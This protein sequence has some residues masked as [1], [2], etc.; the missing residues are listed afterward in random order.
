MN[1]NK[2][3]SGAGLDII[4]LK[5]LFKLLEENR[6]NEINILEFGSGFSTQFLVDYKLY[7]NKN[8]TIDTYDNDAKYAFNNKNN[9]SFVNV[10]ICPLISTNDHNFKKQL[11][12]KK[13][14]QNY[15]RVKHLKL[16]DRLLN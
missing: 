8:I 16:S 9:H 14:M 15:L 12:E 3:K 13:F 1:Y 6:K 5:Q 11:H 7:S 4:A 10:N 2:Y